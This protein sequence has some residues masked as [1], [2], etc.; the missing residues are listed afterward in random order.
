MKTTSRKNRRERPYCN[1][2]DKFAPITFVGISRW[3]ESVGACMERRQTVYFSTACAW[4]R[5]YRETIHNKFGIPD[6]PSFMSDYSMT[7]A[8]VER[9]KADITVHKEMTKQIEVLHTRR[10][11]IIPQR[12]E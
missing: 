8:I 4:C 10:P 7:K 12:I 5:F 6:D 11:K 9:L 3:H 1:Y 2:C